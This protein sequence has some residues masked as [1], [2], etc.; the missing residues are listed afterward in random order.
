MMENSHWGKLNYKTA[1][2]IVTQ[3]L[4][5]HTQLQNSSTYCHT[6]FNITHTITEQQHILDILG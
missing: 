6:V 4:I 1:V 3:Y 2:Y 5:S